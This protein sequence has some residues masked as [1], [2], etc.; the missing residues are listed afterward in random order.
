M[1][2][3]LPLSSPKGDKDDRTSDQRLANAVGDVF[4]RALKWDPDL[5]VDGG[6]VPA[7][8]ATI[9]WSTLQRAAGAA[10]AEFEH[11]GPVSTELA[12]QLA[13]DASIHRVV[14]RGPSEILDVGRTQRVV[15]TAQRRALVARDRGSVGCRAPPAWT[16]AHHVVFWA[17]GGPT[18]LD[19]LVLLCRSCHTGV[20]HR[21]RTIARWADG[22]LSVTRP[23][24][25]SRAA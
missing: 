18:D 21:G 3:S 17:D 22:T 7:V 11:Q 8:S 15:T 2:E 13:C 9:D 5:P 24:R 14:T 10:P 1:F 25:R 4:M 6:R 19:N 12:R 23:P 16:D 20:H